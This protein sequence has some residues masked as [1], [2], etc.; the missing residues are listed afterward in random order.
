MYNN[1]YKC[2]KR[3]ITWQNDGVDPAIPLTI[4]KGSI[5]RILWSDGQFKEF[6]GRPEK[7]DKVITL[8]LPNEYVDKYFCKV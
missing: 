5:W 3:F 1:N 2:K 4:A 8:I 6:T 7:D